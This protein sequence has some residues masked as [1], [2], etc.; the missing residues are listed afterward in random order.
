MPVVKDEE[1]NIQEK[2]YTAEG[3][4]A[5]EAISERSGEPVIRTYD[6]GGRVQKIMGYGKGG[7]VDS[8]IKAEKAGGVIGV[9][10][11]KK[12]KKLTK[13]KKTKEKSSIIKEI[14]RGILRGMP[15]VGPVLMAHDLHEIKKAKKRAASKLGRTVG[16]QGVKKSYKA[17]N[18]K[19]DK[20]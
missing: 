19:L 16:K 13:G 18:R 3:I 1:G 14:G 10:I 8:N 20:K 7:A 11:A 9:K 17:M 15:G 2:P 12:A 6:A 4:A 5:A